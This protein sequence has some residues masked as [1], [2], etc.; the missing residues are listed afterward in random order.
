MKR[1]LK[2]LTAIVLV[3]SI[4]LSISLS[5]CGRGKKDKIEKSIDDNNVEKAQP[6]P[7]IDL[8]KIRPDESGKIMV[9]MFHNF[10]ESF[11]PT[12]YDKGEY[13]ITF[14]GFEKLLHTLYNN[15]YRLISFKDYLENNITVQ[16]GCVPMVFTF[17]DG[18]SGQFNFIEENGELKVNR[19][20]AV[21]IMED[22]NKLHPDFGLKGMFFVNL[23][24][25]TFNGKGE[26]QQRLKYLIGKGFEIGNHTFNHINL[27]DAKSSEKIQQ[28]LGKNQK[29]MYELVPGY[30]MYAFSLPYGAPSNDLMKYVIKGEFEG[31][32]YENLAIVEVGWDPALSPVNKKYDP[33]STHRVRAPGINPEK[34]DLNWW[35]E[36]ISRKDEYVSDGNPKKVTIPKEKSDVLDMEKLKD[37]ELITY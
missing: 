14:D 33:V 37:T 34:F 28:E 24:L 29:K 36:N 16:A 11:T 12:K 23:G 6:E 32:K 8:E 22:F 31:E 13:T 10:V 17:D 18:T 2:I 19:N 21:G 4:A 30:K 20:S 26:L 3:V 1:F 27:K 25:S 35:L 9:V 15:G 7:E 5:G